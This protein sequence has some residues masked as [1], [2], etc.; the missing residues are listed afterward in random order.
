MAIANNMQIERQ[1]LHNEPTSR[2]FPKVRGGTC[3]FC[4]VLDQYAAA[5]HQYKLCEHYRGMQL[6]CSYCPSE[7][8]PDDVIKKSVMKIY[9]HPE[10]PGKLIVVCDNYECEKNHQ[11]RF[12]INS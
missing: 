5:E 7:R 9:D 4:G 8:N 3:E 10:K 11:E 2:S 6:H 12:R 1:G